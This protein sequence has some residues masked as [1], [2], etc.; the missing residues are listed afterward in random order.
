MPDDNCSGKGLRGSGRSRPPGLAPPPTRPGR[1][2][3]ARPRSTLGRVLCPW[4]WGNRCRRRRWRRLWQRP[5]RRKGARHRPCVSRRPL[6]SLHVR[7]RRGRQAVHP[8][9][10]RLRFH[11]RGRR[12]RPRIRLRCQIRPHERP[13]RRPLRD[14]ISRAIRRCST[15]VGGPDH[16]L[17]WLL[18]VD[19]RATF[20]GD[21]ADSRPTAWNGRSAIWRQ[22]NFLGAGPVHDQANENDVHAAK[23]HAKCA[24]KEH[25]LTSVGTATLRSY[26]DDITISER[27]YSRHL[28]RLRGRLGSRC[29]ALCSSPAVLPVNSASDLRVPPCGDS[30]RDPD[31]DSAAALR[32]RVF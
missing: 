6:L 16:E 10:R 21:S 15:I 5:L 28:P 13:L 7:L 1:V 31:A 27:A 11:H 20:C 17:A 26:S 12:R 30:T 29:K 25:L 9:H 2:L 4:W 3:F 19:S 14:L 22:K 24:L 32:R 18:R 23:S 8:L